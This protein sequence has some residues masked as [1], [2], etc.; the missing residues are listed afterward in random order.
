M[1]MPPPRKSRKLPSCLT[2]ISDEQWLQ[3][4]KGPEPPHALFYQCWQMGKPTF[5]DQVET[6]AVAFN[7]DGDYIDFLFNPEFWAGLSHYDR[8]FVVCHE[9]L[10]VILNHGHRSKNATDKYRANKALD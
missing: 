8:L 2:M 6:A 9:C 5:T 7:K 1:K 4:S 3:I 10:H